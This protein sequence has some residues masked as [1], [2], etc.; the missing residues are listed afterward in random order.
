MAVLGGKARCSNGRSIRL[1]AIGIMAT[2]LMGAVSLSA[3]SGAAGSLAGGTDLPELPS[4]GHN[5]VTITPRR[6]ADS[7]QPEGF[8]Y[9]PL[10]P[11]ERQTLD[12]S[13]AAAPDVRARTA[14]F[15]LNVTMVDAE[16]PADL[17][18]WPPTL[19]QPNFAVVHVDDP[20]PVPSLVVVPA[21]PDGAI[22]V[23]V[24]GFPAHVVVD[25]VGFVVNSA[26]LGG[27][28][29]PMGP[30]RWIDT[31]TTVR[32]DRSIRPV[33]SSGI[34]VNFSAGQT[35]AQSHQS[36]VL[37]TIIVT[38]AAQPGYLVAW[39]ADRPRPVA[40]SLNF[41]ASQTTANTVLLPLDEHGDAVVA[42]VGGPA[43]V[44]IDIVGYV[45]DGAGVIA[46]VELNL[47][48]RGFTLQPPVSGT[49]RLLPPS[50]RSV[51]PVAGVGP[52]PRNAT[53][54][55]VAMALRQPTEPSYLSIMRSDANRMATSAVHAGPGE[56]RVVTTIV[57][58]GPDGTLRLGVH[59]GW[60]SVDVEVLGWLR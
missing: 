58:L 25:V 38:N 18:A 29:H 57:P 31:R 19:P 13:N 35:R 40:S 56:T 39:P 12:V 1:A 26:T 54:A 49:S 28:F 9:G 45:D 6:V 7:R 24:S 15:V 10:R 20:S 3:S 48:N 5:I 33:D 41:N 8:A 46:G 36:A 59:A 30:I 2:L 55:L 50:T 17:F 23:A 27:D 14:A 60:P 4:A 53:G 43:D 47:L 37:A 52:V 32:S 16:G 11:G 22:E 42:V 44:V 51:V 21:G 34:V